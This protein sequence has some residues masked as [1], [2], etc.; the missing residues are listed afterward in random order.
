MSGFQAY[1][2]KVIMESETSGYL[3]SY[4]LFDSYNNALNSHSLAI[5]WL[6]NSVKNGYGVDLREKYTL[7]N[8]QMLMY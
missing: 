4:S 6:T 1:T 3:I 8:L 5:Q 7:T 2:Y